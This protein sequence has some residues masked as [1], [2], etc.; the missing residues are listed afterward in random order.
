MTKKKEI[1]LNDISKNPDKP[2]LELNGDGLMPLPPPYEDLKF[3][4]VGELSEAQ[5]ERYET[6]LDGVI[7]VGVPKPQSKAEEETLVRKFVD[8]LRKLFSKED[9]W[10]FLQPLALSMENCVKC[11]TCSEACRR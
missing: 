2:L 1:K 7:A 5:R 8:G 3:A 9:N 11:Q 10:T 6:S 4:G